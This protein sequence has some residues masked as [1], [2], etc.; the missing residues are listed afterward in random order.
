MKKG[1]RVLSDTKKKDQ[2][3][4]TTANKAE[5]RWFHQEQTKYIH[6]QTDQGKQPKAGT[7]RLPNSHAYPGQGGVDDAALEENGQLSKIAH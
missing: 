6:Q 3:E 5:Q 7:S 2:S 1:I 4:R